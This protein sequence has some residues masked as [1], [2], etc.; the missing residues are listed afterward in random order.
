M[1]LSFSR[2]SFIV[3]G[4]PVHPLHMW[5]FVSQVDLCGG[6]RLMQYGVMRVVSCLCHIAQCVGAE[7]GTV[8]Q[9]FEEILRGNLFRSLSESS[10]FTPLSRI[11]DLRLA[12]MWQLS[13]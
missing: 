3:V 11:R 13:P 4:S 8:T 1:P 2:Y 10:L 5:S 7:I 9:T 6:E 12:S